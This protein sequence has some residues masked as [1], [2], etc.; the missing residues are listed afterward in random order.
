MDFVTFAEQRRK[1]V[2]TLKLYGYIK[3]PAIER[4]FLSVPR[5]EFVPPH[6]RDKAYLD[7]PLPIGHGQT[8][9]APHMV[10][11]M[12]EELQPKY[13]DKVLEVGTGSGYQAAI[14]A[15]VINPDRK[16]GGMV[17]TIER[18][19]ELAEFAIKNLKKTGYLEVVKVVIGDGSLGFDEA[20]PYEKIIVTAG[21]PHIP[22]KLIEQLASP[23]R[24]V[25]P[26]GG[27]YEQTLLVVNKD[28]K[29]K[30][31]VTESIPCV[32][33]PLIGKDGWQE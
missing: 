23:G 21:A 31:R 33:V 26:V 22:K 9:S 20:A 25:I 14:L 2:E 11:I 30:I 6:L 18:I 17:H 29:G 19:P 13:G 4:A 12:T 27:R 7:M 24:M 28:E 3:T 1:L 5:E 16:S 8:I 15:E 10:A 32:F